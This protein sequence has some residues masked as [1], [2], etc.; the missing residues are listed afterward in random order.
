MRTTGRGGGF[1]AYSYL[2]KPEFD[3]DEIEKEIGKILKKRADE[4]E[5]VTKCRV[6]KEYIKSITRHLFFLVWYS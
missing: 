2:K 5:Y 4:F 6:R 3:S 1:R